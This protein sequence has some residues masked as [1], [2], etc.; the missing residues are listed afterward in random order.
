MA[1]GFQAW[2]RSPEARKQTLLG[3]E[4]PKD[5]ADTYLPAMQHLFGTASLGVTEWVLIIAVGAVIYIVVEMEK[6]MSTL[7]ATSS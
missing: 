4:P 5:L 3:L 6:R 1:P 2:N 7:R